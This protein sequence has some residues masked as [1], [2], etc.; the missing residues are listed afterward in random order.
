[1]CWH[2]SCRAPAA[3]PGSRSEKG[4]GRRGNGAEFELLAGFLR[5]T[6]SAGGNATNKL[7]DAE[8]K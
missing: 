5:R 7:T 1:M 3:R 4:A 6:T 8:P 2:G